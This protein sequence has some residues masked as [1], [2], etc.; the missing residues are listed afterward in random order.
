[1]RA[2]GRALKRR[3]RALPHCNGREKRD[4]ATRCLESATTI[5]GYLLENRSEILQMIEGSPGPPGFAPDETCAHP[6]KRSV[7]P[8]SSGGSAT[9]SPAAVCR[10]SC[11]LIQSKARLSSLNQRNGKRRRL[12]TKAAGTAALPVVQRRGR[13][14]YRRSS[15]MRRIKKNALRRRDE[16]LKGRLQSGAG[17]PSG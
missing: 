6:P 1:M 11:S 7:S 17:F 12:R 8:V 3:H 9:R 5:S 2:C 10:A 14:I 15:A 16:R 4:D 13:R